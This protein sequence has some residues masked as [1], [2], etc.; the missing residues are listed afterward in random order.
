MA[1]MVSGC[2]TLADLRDDPDTIGAGGEAGASPT[3]GA[4]A[5]GGGGSTSGCDPLDTAACG[6]GKCTYDGTS[7]MPSCGPAGS[8]RAYQSCQSDAECEAGTYCH[9]HLTTCKPFCDNDTDCGGGA[10]E[11]APTGSSDAPLPFETCVAMCDPV[12]GTWCDDGTAC[13]FAEPTHFQ[14]WDCGS[15]TGLG[16]GVACSDGDLVCGNGLT[17]V[18]G[19]CQRYCYLTEP[20][21]SECSGSCADVLSR[22][23]V[24]EGKPVGACL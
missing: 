14:H 20:A 24:F 1:L 16:L 13:F 6:S 4:P 8:R 23:A 18:A 5:E 10:G 9:P 15:S 2:A 12:E 11:C 21:P 22:E 17:C 19:T 7:A 3:G